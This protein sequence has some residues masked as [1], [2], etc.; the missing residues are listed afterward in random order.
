MTVYL[1]AAVNYAARGWPTFPCAARSK[2]PLTRHGLHDA[3]TDRDTIATW[4]RRWPDAN[5]AIRT[6]SG[7]LV[8]DVDDLSAIAQIPAL[9]RTLTVATGSGRGMHFY[10]TGDGPSTAGKL[11]PGIDS[12]GHGGYVIAPPSVHPETGLG[13]AWESRAPLAPAPS[14]LLE[15]LA[16]DARRRHAERPSTPRPRS[17]TW[18]SGTL[19]TMPASEYAPRLTG[20]PLTA[21]KIRC[22]FH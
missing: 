20:A 4:W 19:K 9:P 10:F 16:D 14:W 8:I 18:T 15:R 7:L 21:G 6:G 17:H 3:T 2:R 22:P 12:R 13:Y 11:A 5:V 1:D